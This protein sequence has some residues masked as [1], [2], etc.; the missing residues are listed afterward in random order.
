MGCRRSVSRKLA[1][2][3]TTDDRH[4]D[5]PIQGTTDGEVLYLAAKGGEP[6]IGGGKIA[7]DAAALLAVLGTR[8]RAERTHPLYR[9]IV[10]C[11]VGRRAAGSLASG[12]TLLVA[13][14]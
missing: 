5:L 1:E 10:R 4:F 7:N 14:R 13:P 2:T 9:R 3:R 11:E 12:T 6:M 8:R